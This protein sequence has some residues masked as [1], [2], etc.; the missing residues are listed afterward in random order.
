[1][2]IPADLLRTC[3]QV[4]QQPVDDLWT[5][6]LRNLPTGTQQPQFKDPPAR[7]LADLLTS[8]PR[9]RSDSRYS[10]DPE[11]ADPTS[12]QVQQPTLSL[13]VAPDPRDHPERNTTME[14]NSRLSVVVGGQYGSEGK[15]AIAGHLTKPQSRP[16]YCVR[17]GGPNAGHTV[18]GNGPEGPRHPWR[19][20][21]IPVAAVT[22]PDATLVIAAGSEIDP[23]VLTYEAELLEDYGHNIWERLYID[24]QATVLEK[25]HIETETTLDIHTKIGS[26]GKGI[27]AARA[28][29]I[30]RTAQIWGEATELHR[31]FPIYTDDFLQGALEEGAHVVIEGTQGYGLGLHAGHY[32]QCT[33]NDA[34]AIDFLAMAGISP[35]ASYIGTFRAYVVARVYPIRVAGNSGP[36]KGETTWEELG[37]EPELTTVTRKVR[38]VGKW[39]PDLVQEAVRAN[40]GPSHVRVCLTM[41]DHA[42]PETAN[43]TGPLELLPEPAQRWIQQVE[44]ETNAPVAMVG[45]GPD[46]IAGGWR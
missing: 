32:P 15:G 23:D 40:G 6:L 18:L 14:I 28:D 44:R 8:L 3:R 25:K 7:I 1:M 24:Y 27:G 36:L 33:S 13:L 38:R 42:V 37:L 12:Q 29:R 39:D 30:M 45:T 26:T 31:Q 22:N 34:R 10:A 46:T 17:V 19:L 35:W 4:G 9:G 43:Y 20:R 21:T 41:L 11:P 5:N 16:V 2:T